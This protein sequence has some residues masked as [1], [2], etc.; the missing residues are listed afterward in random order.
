VPDNDELNPA[1]PTAQNPS[2][3]ELGQ[4]EVSRES[5][6]ELE[7]LIAQK[8]R[9][10]ASKDA[11]VSELEQAMTSLENEITTLNQTV[12]ESNDKMDKLSE[13]LNQAV[14]SYKA[15]VVRANPGVP[16]ELITGDSIE[17]IADSL[18]SARELV[19][20]IRNG[21]EAEISLVRV[22]IGAP[23]RAAP[24]LSALSPREKIQY[25]VGGFSS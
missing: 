19:T 9:E 11:R 18:A 2:E 1:E 20:K 23:E 22:P 5:I 12:A 13:S 7:N 21:M 16:E 10:I 8:D 3:D 6:A 4:S 15:L 25:A 14:S 24:D 17:A